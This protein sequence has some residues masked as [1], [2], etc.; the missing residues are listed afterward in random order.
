M[1]RIDKNNTWKDIKEK[2]VSSFMNRDIIEGSSLS[3][4]ITEDNEWCAEA[5]MVTDYSKISYQE[6]EITVKKHILFNLL[7]LSGNEDKNNTEENK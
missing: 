3:R 1:G 7:T 4:K 6:Y 2:W 5:Y